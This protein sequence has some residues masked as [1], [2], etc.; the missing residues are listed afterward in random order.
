MQSDMDVDVLYFNI[1]CGHSQADKI[2]YVI[3]EA[4]TKGYLTKPMVMTVKGRGEEEGNKVLQE[5]S[6]NYP[7]Y[8]KNDMNEACLLVKKLCEEEGVKA[9]ENAKILEERMSHLKKRYNKNRISAFM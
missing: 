5:L 1:F 7:I 4:Y 9:D 2:A 8:I 3:K 6:V